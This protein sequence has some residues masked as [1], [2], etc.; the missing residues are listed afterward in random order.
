MRQAWIEFPTDIHNK[1]HIFSPPS[2]LGQILRRIALIRLHNPPIH[3]LRIPICRINNHLPICHCQ[4]LESISSAKLPA[5]RTT[6]G[7]PPALDVV[8]AGAGRW[9]A[10]GGVGAWGCSRDVRVD[11]VGVGAGA[12]GGVAGAFER[13]DGPLRGGCYHH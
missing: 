11:G 4:R 3:K 1:K 6:D 13:D 10:G 7:I 8:V 2:T 5:P 12:I 9:A